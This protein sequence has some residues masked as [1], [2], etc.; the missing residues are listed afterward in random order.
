MKPDQSKPFSVPKDFGQVDG[1]PISN[2]CTILSE[3]DD[4]LEKKSPSVEYILCKPF[5]Y[6]KLPFGF[7]FNFNSYGHSAV[8][9]TD[10]DNNDIVMNIEGKVEGKPMVQFYKASD[11]FYGT[12]PN[13]HG[14][15]K[16]A[17][18]NRDM[19]GIRIEN[20]DPNDVKKCMNIF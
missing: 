10:S 14:S 7:G 15:Q 2:K 5:A 20:V 11:Y 19:V 6:I 9:Y 13:K 16:G 4:V 18:Y 1:T 8:R 12:D 3:I 17:M